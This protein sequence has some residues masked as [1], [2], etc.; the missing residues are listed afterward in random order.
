MNHEQCFFIWQIFALWPHKNWIKKTL[1]V[2]L[3]KNTI[4]L[5][6]MVKLLKPQ[7]WK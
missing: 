7:N 5:E 2:N 4:F 1:N 6:K 3:K